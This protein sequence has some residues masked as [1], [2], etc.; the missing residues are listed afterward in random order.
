MHVCELYYADGQVITSGE[1]R[2][3]ILLYFVFD[4]CLEV[5]DPLVEYELYTVPNII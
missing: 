1:K 5:S 2:V 4:I 3:I